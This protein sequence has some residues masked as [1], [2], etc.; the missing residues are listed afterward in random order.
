MERE[1]FFEATR[2]MTGSRDTGAQLFCSMLRAAGVEARLVS[3]LQPLQFRAVE[4]QQTPQR[5]YAMVI[6][7]SARSRQGTPER[8]TRSMLQNEE[9]PSPTTL[10]LMDQITPNGEHTGNA[11]S[12]K[13]PTR[14]LGKLVELFLNPC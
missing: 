9:T 6:P 8:G 3:S 13:L 1:D 7:E 10:S 14:N 12:S 4:K 11:I 2:T 5:H